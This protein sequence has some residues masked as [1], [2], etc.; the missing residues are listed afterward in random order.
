MAVLASHQRVWSAF[1]HGGE[2]EVQ[3]M[4][5]HIGLHMAAVGLN[6]ADVMALGDRV[7][8]EPQQVSDQRISGRNGRRRGPFPVRIGQQRLGNSATTAWRSPGARECSFLNQAACVFSIRAG[9]STFRRWDSSPPIQS[10]EPTAQ[11]GAHAS[12]DLVD[13]PLARIGQPRRALAE[14]GPAQQSG[15]P[16][17]FP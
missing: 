14:Q 16:R 1:A 13:L 8:Q 11:Q 2:V 15:V 12:G 7:C 6:T 17:R 3:F 4:A 5:L 10:Q 9:A